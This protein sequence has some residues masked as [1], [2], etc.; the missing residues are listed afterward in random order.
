[1]NDSRVISVGIFFDG[2][3]NNGV[4][5]L[6]PDKPLNN[7]ESYYGTFTNIYK[8]YSLF[9]GDEKIYIE[10]I[11]TVTGSE[12]NNFAMATCANPPY[13]NGYSSDDKLQKAGDFVERIIHD[14]TKEYHF[15]IYGFGRGGM[16]ARTFCNQ[17]L[18]HY[19]SENFR[20]RF[21]GAFDTV[22]SKPFNNYNLNIPAQVESAL[23]I[24]AVNESRF[25]FPLT[26]FFENSKIMEDQ[27]LENTSSVWKEIFV[28][29]DHADIGGGYLEGPQSVY[30]STDFIHIDDLHHYVSDIRNEKT[31]AEGN[32]IWDA[33]LS[34]YEIET[35]NGLSQAYVCRDKVYNDLSKVYGKLMLEE[36]NA[37]VSIFST[38]ND[39]Y[40]GTDY[41]KHPFLSRFYIKIKEYIKDLSAGKKPIYDFW[42]FADY[43]H[44]S[45]NF[46]LYSNSFLKKSQREINIELINNGLNVSSS[47]S[48]DQTS[49]TRLSVD[50]HLPED[51]FVAD[52]L[53]GT[54]V[55]NN[56][57]W[58]RSIL[59]T[60][61]AI[62]LNEIKN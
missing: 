30:I 50:L 3:G 16:L 41:N 26:G 21:L 48:V 54:S 32:K 31:N 39:A 62:T 14:Q 7:N 24:C 55:P 12:D 8:L 9:I 56:D 28:P 47:T 27:K 15:Y 2:T 35:A 51:S 33:L 58:D 17:L 37:K 46:G 45:A 11:G 6:S 25:F 34:G 23:H 53:Y 36:T 4:N 59:K 1:M 49:R 61:T 52:F 22:E 18:A 40:F 44:I 5:I 10:G 13:G 43:T 19:S 60:Q 20:I 38:D 42:K 29:G 57:I